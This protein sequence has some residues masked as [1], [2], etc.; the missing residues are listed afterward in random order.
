MPRALRYSRIYISTYI[1]AKY[2]ASFCHTAK[3][4]LLFSDHSLRHTRRGTWMSTT[5]NTTQQANGSKTRGHRNDFGPLK[6]TKKLSHPLLQHNEYPYLLYTMNASR[7]IL[8]RPRTLPKVGS[9]GP[10]KQSQNNFFVVSNTTN[11]T[12]TTE[13]L[14]PSS[15]ARPSARSIQILL[16][17]I[18]VGHRASLHTIECMIRNSTNHSE[19]SSGDAGVVVTADD[20]IDLIAQ[21]RS[22]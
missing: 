2:D 22:I 18:G 16:G 5:K 12:N 14:S 7:T 17:N 4:S 1:L 9:T 6:L 11:T 21:I 19:E 20:M 8:L 10:H 13:A 15:F 3:A